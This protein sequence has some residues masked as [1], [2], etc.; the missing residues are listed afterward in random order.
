MRPAVLTL[1]AAAV[2][3]CGHDHG[4]AH[5]R[6]LPRPDPVA[7]LRT[8]SPR[9]PRL[10]NYRIDA[11]LDAARHAVTAT[12]TLTWTNGGHDAVD[13]LPFHLYLN[14]FKN[15]SSLFMRTSHGEMR[16]ARANDGGWGW[17]DV[18]KL[19]IDGVPYQLRFVPGPN[20]DKLDQTVAEVKLA[21]PVQPGQT[22]AIDVAFDDQ[23]PEVFAR[24]GD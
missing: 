14:A 20:G 2:A 22:V 3:S 9:S 23:L 19:T 11:K 15:E 7:A 6:S 13:T 8:G 1:F 5:V 12:E 10:A 16:G 24:T 21:S 18:S 17:I 4:P